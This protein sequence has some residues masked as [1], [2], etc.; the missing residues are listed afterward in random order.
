MA[1]IDKEKEA[2]GAGSELSEKVQKEVENQSRT[3]ISPSAMISYILSGFGD[4]NWDEFKNTYKLFY[5]TT[6]L[7][8]KPMTFAATE[9]AV[10]VVDALDNSISGP[11][12]DRTR[13]RWGRLRP[14]LLITLP[15]WFIGSFF[16]W[17][18]PADW[19][20]MRLFVVLTLI[21]YI[22]SIAFS[23]YYPAREAIRFNLTPNVDERNRLI[24]IESYA[25]LTGTWI[26][27]LFP[28]FVDFLPRTIPSRSI[29]TGGAFFF[30]ALVVVFRIYGFFKLRERVPLASRETLQETSILK[31]FKQLAGCRPMWIILLRNFFA[32]GKS[33]S[34]DMESYF[35]LNNMG[36]LSYGSIAGIFTGLP[37]YFILPLAPKLTKKMGLRNFASFSYLFGAV[38]YFIFFIVGYKPTGNATVNLIWVIVALTFCGAPNSWQRYSEKALPGDLYDYVE[39]KT[40]VRNEGMITAVNG[41]G[42]LVSK[43]AAKLLSGAI[44]SAIKYKP[45]LNEYGVVVPQTDPLMLKRIWMVY[46]LAPAIGRT[47]EGLVLRF[48]NVHGKVREEMMFELAKTRAAKIVDKGP[49][50]ETGASQ[51]ET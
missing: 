46:A 29:F 43:Q 26:T 3:F 23:F 49:Q 30:I 1:S 20:Q 4:K 2:Q 5:N 14:Y 50:G 27:S 6:F 18:L 33:T 13:T 28:L 38:G 39:W 41:Y 16:P 24:A 22:D 42:E 35:W 12:L 10:G 11:I 19:S 40:G 34:R 48:F 44:I 51:E 25:N 32:V 9:A 15:L 31:S 36:K 47:L 8:V 7:N 37:S 17:I 21:Y 45:L